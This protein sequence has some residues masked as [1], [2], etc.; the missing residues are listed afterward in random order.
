MKLLYT[1]II[2]FINVVF[3]F[4]VEY[5]IHSAFNTSIIEMECSEIQAEGVRGNYLFILTTDSGIFG[6]RKLSVKCEDIVSISNF[7]DRKTIT[8]CE[9]LF[10][11]INNNQLFL[12]DSDSLKKLLK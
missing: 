10:D 12:T 4:Q 8:D 3:S 7:K 9:E 2:L 11:S 1:L 6:E 5:K